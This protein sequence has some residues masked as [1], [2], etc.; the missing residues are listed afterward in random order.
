MLWMNSLADSQC[1]TTKKKYKEANNEPLTTECNSN[2]LQ[3]YAMFT[4]EGEG[5]RDS[6]TWFGNR[7][8]AYG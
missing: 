8:L 6:V 1:V 5:G 2:T 3:V 7:N 4:F